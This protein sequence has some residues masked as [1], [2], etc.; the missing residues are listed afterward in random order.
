[1]QEIIVIA[2]GQTEEAFI[3]RV[4]APVFHSQQIFLKPVL[5]K[6][7]STAKGGAVTFD[8]LKLNVRNEI[9]RNQNIKL[10]TF[11][12]LYGLDTSFPDFNQAQSIQDVYLRVEHLEQALHR[13]L[14]AF[15]ECRPERI[16]THI[17]P[18]EFE[19]LLFS[20][21]EQL[22]SIE[23]TWQRSHVTLQR[24]RDE[25]DSPEHINNGYETKP[26]KR[27]ED[28][29]HPK[30]KKTTHGPRIAQHIGVE[31]MEQECAHFKS[32]MDKIRALG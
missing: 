31:R 26:S 4:V 19:G 29:L 23:P 21:V 13:E 32:W 16:I 20:D 24:M 14:I 11:L 27:L 15:V 12:D 2:E 9:R 7:S 6:T 10:T 18:Y 5:M 3:K 1:M 8:R 30:Y 22:C 17:Q 28:N 25:V